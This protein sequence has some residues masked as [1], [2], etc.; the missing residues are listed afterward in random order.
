MQN[1]AP[2]PQESAEEVAAR[3]G[4]ALS[5]LFEARALALWVRHDGGYFL[6]LAFHA[7]QSK[8]APQNVAFDP[9]SWPSEAFFTV[10]GEGGTRD[11]AIRLG[12]LGEETAAPSLLL[13]LGQLGLALFWLESED[14]LLSD[15]WK[16]IF[17][18]ARAQSAAW[19]EM[20]TRAERLNRA[21]RQFASVISGVVDGREPGRDGFGE[22]VAYYA[23]L[24]ARKMGLGEEE[25]QKIEFA[26]LLHGLGRISIPDA[27]LQKQ[28]AL[29]PPELEQVRAAT[30]VGANWLATVDGLEEVAFLV[31]HQ[32]EKFNGSGVPA[33]LSGSEIPLGSRILAVAT[34][35]AAMTARRADRAP[36][37]VVG[38]AMESVAQE[39]GGALDP[40]VV[41]AF[42]SAMG[43]SVS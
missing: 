4:Q 35:F 20:A 2:A 28:G 34:R 14:G 11:L 1:S 18:A 21:F 37:S 8:A 9:Q 13:P 7:G 10:E 19:L 15:D 36:L 26:A 6:H 39:S 40:R 24:T 23:G 38:G 22:A 41:E 43:R 27:I 32:G 29:S 25:A 42:L 5:E 33:A 16:P 30:A 31:R 17:E 12:L 3:L